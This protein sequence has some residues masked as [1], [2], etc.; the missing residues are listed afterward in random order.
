MNSKDTWE[1]IQEQIKIN[2]GLNGLAELK[3]CPKCDKM[4][5]MKTHH[6]GDLCDTSYDSYSCLDPKCGWSSR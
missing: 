3:H 2:Y 1:S 6:S 4:S 5:V